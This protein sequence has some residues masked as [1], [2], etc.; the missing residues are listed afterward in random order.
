MNYDIVKGKD[1]KDHWKIVKQ[2]ATY[3]PERLIFKFENLFNGNKQLCK[4]SRETKPKPSHIFSRSNRFS[5]DVVHQFANENWR[6]ILAE[7]GAPIMTKI[8]RRTVKQIGKIFAAIPAEDLI[9]P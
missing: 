1:G 4:Y 5:A 2:Q 3:T 6:E 8:T 9:I 7:L